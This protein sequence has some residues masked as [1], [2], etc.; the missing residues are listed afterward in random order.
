MA[1]RRDSGDCSLMSRRL[2]NVTHFRI[3][4]CDVTATFIRLHI[5]SEERSLVFR[6]AFA[7]CFT[8]AGPGGIQG[9]IC[10]SFVTAKASMSAFAF[11]MLNLATM[12]VS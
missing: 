8:L 12:P 7:A 9:H 6:E 1:P 5:P 10:M 2:Q 3:L 11:S 4:A